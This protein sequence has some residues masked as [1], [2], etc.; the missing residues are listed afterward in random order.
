MISLQVLMLNYINLILSLLD[1]K[2]FF[3]NF[4]KNILTRIQK[5]L[6]RYGILI[7]I[8]HSQFCRFMNLYLYLDKFCTGNFV[9]DPILNFMNFY[10][11]NGLRESLKSLFFNSQITDLFWIF[12][13]IST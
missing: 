12:W 7:P 11:L 2:I 4:S 8:L 9:L 13:R 1:K 10:L 5:S 3:Q 6:S